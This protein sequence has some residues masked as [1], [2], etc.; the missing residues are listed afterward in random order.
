MMKVN[1]DSIYSCYVIDEFQTSEGRI[2]Y[3]VTCKIKHENFLSKLFNNKF[4][5][6]KVIDKIYFTYEIKEACNICN[7]HTYDI[8]NKKGLVK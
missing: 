8:F 7:K 5:V 3:K 2:H 4:F 6:R 1:I